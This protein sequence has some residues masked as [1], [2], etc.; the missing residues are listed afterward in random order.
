MKSIYAF[1]F[2]A[3][4]ACSRNDAAPPMT[5]ADAT[6]ASS[7][8]MATASAAPSPPRKL[9]RH[10]LDQ[11]YDAINVRDPRDKQIATATSR[12]GPPGRVTPE[13]SYWYGVSDSESCFSLQITAD[14]MQVSS[15]APEHCGLP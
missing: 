13:G 9:T 12:L 4:A 7:A 6:H 11:A 10:D 2:L 1:S 8:P 5:S 15:A 3:L 14:Q